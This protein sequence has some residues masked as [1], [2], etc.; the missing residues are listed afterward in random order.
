MAIPFSQA[1]AAT[2]DK[3]VANKPAD[4]WSDSTFLKALEGMGGVKKV[5]GGETLTVVLDYKSNPAADFLATEATTTSTSKTEVMTMAQYDWALLVVPTNWSF[6]DEALNSSTDRKVDLIASLV[7]NALTSH[8]QAV[9]DALFAATG[10]TDGCNTLID[11]YSENG[12]GTV[13]GIVSGTE[14]WWKGQFKDWGTDTG[15]T[16]LADYETL[17]NAC[18]KGSA[19]KKPNVI[20]GGSAMHGLYTAALTANQRFIGGGKASGSFTEIAFKNIPYLF[21][22]EC[23]ANENAFMFSTADTKLYVVSSAWRQRR[24]AVEHINGIFMNQKLFSVCQLAT[25]NRSRGGVIFS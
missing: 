14:T 7:D 1:V 20:V 19:G 15:A 2:F 9:E 10:G 13:G 12:E 16:L 3:V 5:S 8:D 24:K 25:G 6:R 4:Q 18:A 17:Y 21:S 23:A 11:I 22:S